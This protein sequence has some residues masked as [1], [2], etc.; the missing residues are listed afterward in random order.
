[1]HACM[2][3]TSYRLRPEE[4]K[5]RRRAKVWSEH[6]ASTSRYGMDLRSDQT[7]VYV[8]KIITRQRSGD[9]SI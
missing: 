9:T 2:D 4:K 6:R 7:A 8:M 3:Y 5:P 1:M